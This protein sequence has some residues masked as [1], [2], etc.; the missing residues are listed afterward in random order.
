MQKSELIDRINS[1]KE[2]LSFTSLKEFSKSPASFISYKLRET[3]EETSAMRVG[4]AFHCAVLE[5][6]KFEHTYSVLLKSMLPVPD[7]D[8]RNSENKK[9]KDAFY[10][11]AETEGKTILT[12]EEYNECIL[13]KTLCNSNQITKR[14]IS[15]C[16]KMESYQQ[17]EYNGLKFHGYIDAFGQGTIIDL[18]KVQDA[19]PLKISRS[20]LF[21]KW[22]LQGA[23][24][25]LS[26]IADEFTQFYN[27][28]VDKISPAI[29][30]LSESSKQ[31]AYSQLKTLTDEFKRCTDEGS[32][33]CGY[34]FF[35][36]NLRGIFTI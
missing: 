32:W 17:F 21:D 26:P 15:V 8:F 6:E 16:N 28:C 24:Y 14:Y 18:K 22:H 2:K 35:S 34:E 4:S 1:G 13:Y 5:P 7:S 29:Y 20:A 3:K 19:S 30:E 27:L 9:F 12:E 10:K 23:L 11:N 31:I 36:N 25:L 33:D